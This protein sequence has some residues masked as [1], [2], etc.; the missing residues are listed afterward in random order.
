VVRTELTTYESSREAMHLFQ[1]EAKAIALL[2]HPGILPLY[3]YGEQSVNGA[4]L[5]YLVMPYREEGSLAN[6]LQKGGVASLSL[7]GVE[8]IVQQAAAALHY[9]HDH[10]V[11]H[12]DVKPSNFLMRIR[13]DNPRRF[14][15][16][17]A[18]FGIA[19]LSMFI[20]S[21]SL[22]IRGTPT[23]MAP[24]QWEG[25]PVP[26][27]DQYALAVMVYGLLTGRPPF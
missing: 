1:G 11:V 18:D 16:L 27:T 5:T 26:A 14:D 24:E 8:Q 12:Q 7:Q 19:K 20:S 4:M 25:H 2:D 9:A 21:T 3:D 15:L 10:Q 13:G 22:S 23:Y 17:L 6:W